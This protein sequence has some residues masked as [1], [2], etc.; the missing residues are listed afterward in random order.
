MSASAGADAIAYEQAGYIHLLDIASGLT[1]RLAIEVNGDLPWAR[2]QFKTLAA[3]M[4]PLPSPGPICSAIS[5]R[6]L[7]RRS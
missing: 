1:K 3:A 7:P 5:A 6:P 4:S 2:P